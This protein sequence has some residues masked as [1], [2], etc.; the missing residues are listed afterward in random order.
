MIPLVATETFSTADTII[1][2]TGTAAKRSKKSVTNSVP[3][4][5]SCIFAYI[6]NL[7][8]AQIYDIKILTF[9]QNFNNISFFEG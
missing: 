1:A 7:A 9:L 5:N 2:L 6:K 8:Y 3:Q 4:A